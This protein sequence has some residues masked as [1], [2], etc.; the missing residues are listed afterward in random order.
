MSEPE[1]EEKH[2]GGRHIFLF[3]GGAVVILVLIKL[4][5]DNLMN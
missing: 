3:L 5:I 4:L 2:S 1:Q